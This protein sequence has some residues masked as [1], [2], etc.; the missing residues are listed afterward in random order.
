[1]AIGRSAVEIVL[2]SRNRAKLREVRAV[3]EPEGVR[4]LSLDEAGFDEDLIERGETFEE[5]AAA[6]ALAVA[7]GTDR[8]SLADDSGLVVEALGGR[9]GVKSARYG[10]P[11]LDDAA[12]VR[13]LLDELARVPAGQRVAEF[14]CVLALA[15]PGRVVAMWSGRVCG[16]IADRPRGAG[17]FGYDPV[18]VYL[19]AGKTFAEMSPEEKSAVSHRGRA[20]RQLR[21]RLADV[22]AG[23]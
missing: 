8:L 3:L 12:R 5:N 17:G 1:M 20:L 11:G 23:A 7:A 9:P 18:F 4:V 2:A 22:L 16:L 13:L 21:R 14:V 19:P 6:K 15:L 10:G